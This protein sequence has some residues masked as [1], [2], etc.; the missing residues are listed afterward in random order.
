MSNK[1]L[2]DATHPE[3]TRVVVL[4]DKKVEDFD[5]EAASKR[6]L[7]GNIYLAKVTRVEPS[8]QAAFIEYGGNRHGFL[9]FSEIHP[10]YYQIPQA[11][12]QA[13]LEELEAE[14]T[15]PAPTQRPTRRRSSGRSSRAESRATATDDDG[16][17]DDSAG[18]EHQTDG[19][20]EANEEPAEAAAAD[21][22]DLVP[23]TDNADD[24]DAVGAAEP[25]P[26]EDV[27]VA[28]AAPAEDE[29]AA[30]IQAEEAADAVAEISADADDTVADEDAAT[31]DAGAKTVAASA[32]EAEEKPAPKRRRRTPAKP[33][34]GGTT[35]KSDDGLADPVV[36][37]EDEEVEVSAVGNADAMEELPER[38]RRSPRR[39]YKIQEVIK[40][41]QILLVQVVK[42]ER[43]NKGAALTTY[44]SLA[45][46]YSVLMPNTS[47]GGGVSRKITDNADRKRL[48]SLVA[49]LEIPEGMGIILRTAGAARTKTEIKRDYEYL[50]RL[51]ESVRDLTLKSIA[52]ELV[53]EEGNLTKRAIRD[54]YS[55]EIDEVLVS[56]ENAYR[57]AK[58]FMKMLMPSHAKNV[59]QYR[60]ATPIFTAYAVE[61]QLDAMFSPTVMLPSK[62]S[63]VINPTEALVAI[64]VNSGKSNKESNI[65]DTATK[66]N[67]EAADEVARQLRLRDLAGLIVIDFIDMDDKRHNRQV[68]KRLKDALKLDRSRIQVGRIS[69]F[70]LLEMSRQ[71]IR[72]GM[73]ETSMVCCPMCEGTGHVRSTQSV[74]LFCLRSL[75]EH[76]LRRSSHHVTLRT[77]S[78]VALYILN[79]KRDHL[80][81]L[82]ER[83]GLTVTVS[84]D[85]QLA[86]QHMEIDIGPM[87]E[88]DP[89]KAPPT[90]Q[91]A[92]DAVGA[93]DEELPE[94]DTS[95]E[96]GARPE[97][98]GE[99][100]SRRRRRRRRRGG[101]GPPGEATARDRDDTEPHGDET[102]ARSPGDTSEDTSENTGEETTGRSADQAADGDTVTEGEDTKRRRR[103]GRRG[104]RRHR[105]DEDT[106]RADAET[107]TD[108]DTERASADEARAEDADQSVDGEVTTI[109]IV[110]GKD[111]QGEESA[112]STP[113]ASAN[114]DA[115]GDD[116]ADEEEEDARDHAGDAPVEAAN[117][118]AAAAPDE[119]DQ[120]VKDPREERTE[121]RRR[122]AGWWQRRSFF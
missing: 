87:V 74:A 111:G 65:E 4:R 57:E 56:G 66:T 109:A 46:R 98:M 31:D 27:A 117:A 79:Q 25:S 6:P 47:R 26:S 76:L 118:D 119:A 55:K 103:R 7:R 88:R 73:V 5:F 48:K 67:L 42:E 20:F 102:S 36:T 45:G 13:L 82:E 78:A 37:D 110:D 24:E 38:K 58:D 71:R 9:A 19:V 105:K 41:R 18:D 60:E 61:S 94:D 108:T 14:E 32:E 52:P 69:P 115:S 86:G 89:D 83:F 49:E 8:L 81:A 72:Q 1:M 28:D 39:V 17:G 96:H 40:R 70:G 68:E 121:T 75:E 30:E 107:E 35:K 23:E 21:G 11:D 34:A 16:D 12:R 95:G 84:A 93:V 22:A 120:P 3:E 77:S 43:G 85:E 53:Y 15:E 91:L 64:D 2:V 116:G 10:D 80:N 50:L 62:G 113:P 29:P 114:G 99:R 44:L 51:W 59:K 122:R 100:T 106:V 63:I 97:P 54:L 104:G 101:D 92:P 90:T 33:K 112:P